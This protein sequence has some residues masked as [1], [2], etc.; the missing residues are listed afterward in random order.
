LG[1]RSLGYG[2]L[3][4]QHDLFRRSGPGGDQQYQR[5]FFCEWGSFQY[6]DEPWRGAIYLSAANAN[7]AK[8]GFDGPRQAFALGANDQLVDPSAYQ[9]LV[10]AWRNGAP[11]RLSAVGS[12]IAG[13]END[14]VAAWLVRRGGSQP[15]GLRNGAPRL[16][17]GR[18]AG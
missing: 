16:G 18:A 1:R 12:V 14:R 4:E 7:G 3:L 15:A 9:N 10:I 8:G 5:L 11:V 13:V 2:G 17:R 6:P